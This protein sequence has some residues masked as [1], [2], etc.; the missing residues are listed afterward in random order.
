VIR[1]RPSEV[2]N[3]SLTPWQECPVVKGERCS[4]QISFFAFADRQ[5]A[6]HCTS[7]M[8]KIN[9]LIAALQEQAAK[10][11]NIDLAIEMTLPK[12]KWPREGTS[13]YYHMFGPWF[14]CGDNNHGECTP[15]FD[16]HE[17]RQEGD[18]LCMR[19][20]GRLDGE[21]SELSRQG[22][23]DEAKKGRAIA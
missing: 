5:R 20:V 11:G 15:P 17:D 7:F 9:D 16:L 13:K 10:H 3:F 1:W 6:S 12:S 4:E 14:L 19:L 18:W 21:V 22:L 2:K 23:R 8:V